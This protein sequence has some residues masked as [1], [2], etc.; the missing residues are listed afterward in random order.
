MLCVAGLLA[1]P[2]P[3]LE[4]LCAPLT[5]EHSQ[6][7]PAAGSRE[8]DQS[9]GG[10]RG[11]GGAGGSAPDVARTGGEGAGQVVIGWAEAGSSG[12]RT[13][14][15]GRRAASGVGAPVHPARASVLGE[16]A[17]TARPPSCRAG[18]LGFCAKAGRVPRN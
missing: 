11:T 9:A 14:E 13:K 10:G 18:A 12:P 1:R 17:P 3:G 4:R 5:R 6:K 8:G 7:R 2:A 15:S 16:D